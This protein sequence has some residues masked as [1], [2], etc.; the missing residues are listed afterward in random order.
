MSF[1]VHQYMKYESH[2]RWINLKGFNLFINV[3]M[4][5]MVALRRKTSSSFFFFLQF[6]GCCAVQS[7]LLNIILPTAKTRRSNSFCFCSG[8]SLVIRSWAS[9]SV[10]ATRSP[11]VRTE[12]SATVSLYSS[13]RREITPTR[14][15]ASSA[16][17]LDWEIK[18]ADRRYVV[19]LCSYSSIKNYI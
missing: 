16:R 10:N 9:V 8:W 15:L 13:T 11:C 18:P 2:I 6:S 7:W 5:T 4:Y 12:K 14:P 3:P 17:S 19:A 1:F